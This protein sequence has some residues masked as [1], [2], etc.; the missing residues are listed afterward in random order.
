MRDLS[1]LPE[2]HRAAPTSALFLARLVYAVNWYNVG[3]VLP[4]VGASFHAGPVEL[5][6]VLG[7]FLLGVGIFQLPAGAISIRYGTR[8]VSLV[9]IAVMG[10]SGAA[11]ALAPSW[12]VLAALRFVAGA[13]AAFFFSPALSLIASYYPAGQRGPII[14]LYNGGFSLGGALGLFG[15]AF[16]GAQLGWATTLG[17]S[18]VALLGATALAAAV[19]PAQLLPSRPSSLGAIWRTGREVLASRSIWALALGLTG[20]WAAIYIVAQYFVTFGQSEHPEWGL[21]AIAALA[22]VV[23]VVSL[24]GGPVGGWLAERG[25]D[26]RLLAAIFGGAAGL[27]VLALPFLPLW[28]LALDMIG[29][30]FADGMVFAI[31]Y[32]MPVYFPETRG[33]GLAFGVAFV[34]S[35]Q[36]SIGSALAV[37]FGVLVARFGYVWAWEWAG[38]LTIAMLPLLWAVQP[39]RGTR[40]PTSERAV[41]SA[42]TP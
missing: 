27:F 33:E 14:G 8:R 16:A 13:A 4:L 39:N 32:L 38:V 29:L 12:P 20:F 23:V 18:G 37:V 41:P 15:G 1:A 42:P 31:L 5:G 6:I 40:G 34:N 30:G 17:I 3:A 25:T 21:G 22:A 2:G 9:G 36:V 11:C 28:A 24:P 19:L 7:A 35:V 10:A 26:R